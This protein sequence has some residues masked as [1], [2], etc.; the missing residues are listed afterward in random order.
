M[1]KNKIYFILIYYAL[2]LIVLA[3]R[4]MATTAPPLLLRVGFLTAVILPTLLSR[5]ACYPAIITLFYTVALEG[6]SFSYMPYTMSLYVIITLVITLFFSRQYK[7]GTIPVFI[8]IFAFYI[9][10]IDLIFGASR[11]DTPIFQKTFYCFVMLGCFLIISN[12]QVDI[13]L[14]QLPLCFAA[15]SI[16]L[17]IAFLTH[18]EQFVISELNGIER[19]GWTDPNYFGTS[20]GMGTV[21]GMMKMFSKEWKSINIFEK[22]VYITTVAVSIPVLILNASRGA[23]VSVIVGFVALLLF[24]KAKWFFKIIFIII[25]AIAV[26]YLYSNEYFELLEY[27]IMNDDGTGSGRTDI[28]VNKL[29]AFMDGSLLKMVFGY[30][31]V[32]GLNISGVTIGFHSDYI[33]FLVDYGIIGFGFL[34]YMLLY[35]IIIAQKGI[36]DKPS[37]IALILYLSSSFLTLEPI[38]TGGL[39]YFTFYL[40]A[41]LL[42]KKTQLLSAC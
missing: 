18:R 5:K 32:A 30:G 6:F 3:S 20:L 4:Q 29:S 7:T 21:I 38:L 33:G 36:T 13:A 37:V 17:S 35:P 1:K 28:W 24:S 42:A 26:Y 39:A 11:F 22:V 34:I 10:F 12:R 31:H 14:A 8:L 2:L 40:Y 23:M 41:L 25:M 9:F 15:T 27:R 19:A 16:V